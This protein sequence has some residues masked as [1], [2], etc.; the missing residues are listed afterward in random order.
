MRGRG[1]GAKDYVSAR[2]VWSV[3]ELEMVKEE[4]F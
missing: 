3:Q 4:G 2:G 1:W